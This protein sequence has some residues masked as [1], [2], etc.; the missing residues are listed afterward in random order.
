MYIK[1]AMSSRVATHIMPTADTE[2]MNHTGNLRRS[3]LSVEQ[4][5]ASSKQGIA[6]ST[7][8]RQVGRHVVH[9]VAE[10]DSMSSMPT[11]L[12]QKKQART[13]LQLHLIR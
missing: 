13:Y 5:R 1:C 10:S 8:D 2:L 7:L 11:A 4:A 3:A 9:L 12:P 6:T